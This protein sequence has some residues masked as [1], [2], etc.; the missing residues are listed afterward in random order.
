VEVAEGG[1]EVGM[2]VVVAGAVGARMG[3]DVGSSTVAVVGLD[4]SVSCA[5]AVPPAERVSSAATVWV[6]DVEMACGGS[7]VGDRTSGS[8]TQ[9]LSAPST[10]STHAPG[11]SSLFLKLYTA[12]HHH[13]FLHYS[14]DT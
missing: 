10:R 1:A 3:G 13:D 8:I 6:A 12:F 4:T 5:T 14:L 11:K 2:G 7:V 9:A